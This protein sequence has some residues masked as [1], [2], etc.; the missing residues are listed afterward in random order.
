MRYVRLH[1]VFIPLLALLTIAP[2]LVHGCSCGHDQPFH[3]QSWLDAAQQLRHGTLYPRWAFSP[4]WQAGEPRFVFY[5]PLSWLL[6]ALLTMLFPMNTVPV[7][8]TW[9]ALTG[10]GF[11]MHYFARRF[12]SPEAALFSVGVYMAN[13]YMLFNAFERG[14]YAELLAAA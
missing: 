3:V 6:G 4:A 14:A 12:A 5:P 8:F 7:I 10:A 2:L 9:I 1:H 13:P 11:S